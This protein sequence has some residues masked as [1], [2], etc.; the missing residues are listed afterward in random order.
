M[1]TPEQVTAV[2]NGKHI[3][4][5]PK[6]IT[7]VK[8]SYEIY[9]LLDT[10]DPYS[11]NDLLKAHSVMMRGLNDEAGNFRARPVGVVDSETGRIIH[12][13]TLPD[14]VPKAVSD[15]QDWAKSHMFICL[16]KAA[17]STT[18]LSLYTHFPTVTDVWADC[19]I[20]SCCQNGILCLRGSP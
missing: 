18:N 8:N 2:L 4:A 16:L 20:L 3:I 9:E 17:F 10:L 15:L 1:L 13:G 12:F 5:P 11:I 14:Y 7:E 19:G 6:D